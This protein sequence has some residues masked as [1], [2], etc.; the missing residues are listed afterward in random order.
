MPGC[1]AEVRH[2]ITRSEWLM[3]DDRLRPGDTY[4]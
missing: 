3:L 2:R 4:P 1:D